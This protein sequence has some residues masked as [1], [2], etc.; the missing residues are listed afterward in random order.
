MKRTYTNRIN[1]LVNR[2]RARLALELIIRP[3]DN[4]VSYIR[5]N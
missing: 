4:I 2:G 5:H 3:N 1:Y